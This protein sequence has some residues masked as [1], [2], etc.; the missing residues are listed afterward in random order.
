MPR[1]AAAYSLNWSKLFQALTA[2]DGCAPLAL[3]DL[4]DREKC[5]QNAFFPKKPLNTVRARITMSSIG[6]QFSI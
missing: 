6:D 2:N 1:K 5:V 4:I 3:P